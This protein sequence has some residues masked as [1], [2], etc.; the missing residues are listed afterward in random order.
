VSEQNKQ[1][2]R[3]YLEKLDPSALSRRGGHRPSWAAAL[4]DAFSGA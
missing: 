2:V 4:A 1:A 3:R